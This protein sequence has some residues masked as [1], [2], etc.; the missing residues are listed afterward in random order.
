MQN[1]IQTHLNFAIITIFAKMWY[2]ILFI[3]SFNIIL[4]IYVS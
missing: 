2:L 3:Q 1:S 4:R